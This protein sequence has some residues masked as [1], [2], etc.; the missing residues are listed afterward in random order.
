MTEYEDPEL[1][2]SHRHTKITTTYEGLMYKNVI[3]TRRKCFP[4]VNI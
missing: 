3:N 2:F 1:T 4:Q